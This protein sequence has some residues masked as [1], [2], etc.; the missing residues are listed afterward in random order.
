MQPGIH[1]GELILHTTNMKSKY[2]YVELLAALILKLTEPFYQST[3][4]NGNTVI[5][6]YNKD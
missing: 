4:N 2:F 3:L 5:I 1:P 6:P